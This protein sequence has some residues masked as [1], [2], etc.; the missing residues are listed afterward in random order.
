MVSFQSHA[1]KHKAKMK[2][3]RKLSLQFKIIQKKLVWIN[4]KKTLNVP[5]YFSLFDSQQRSKIQGIRVFP[6]KMKVKI[7]KIQNKKVGHY[8]AYFFKSTLC[9]I[10]YHC[11]MFCYIRYLYFY[12]YV[13]NFFLSADDH[14]SCFNLF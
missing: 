1:M 6:S 7:L 8:M 3:N 9:F 14:F 13:Y 12:L 5:R 4:T 11:K 2:K 10:F